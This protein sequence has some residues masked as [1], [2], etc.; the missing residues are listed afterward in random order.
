MYIPEDFSYMN[1][2]FQMK[3]NMKMYFITLILI[4][5]FQYIYVANPFNKLS[6]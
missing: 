5:K 6:I 2:F 3:N 1:I 4:Y